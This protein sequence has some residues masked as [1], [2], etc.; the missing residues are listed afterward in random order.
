MYAHTQRTLRLLEVVCRCVQMS[1][2][3]LLVGETGV[4]KTAAVNY[5]AAMSGVC[6]M[7]SSAIDTYTVEPLIRTP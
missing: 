2:P 1:E 4:G 5:L 6:V 3:V 7:A